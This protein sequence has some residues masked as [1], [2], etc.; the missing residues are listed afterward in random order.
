MLQALDQENFKNYR[1]VSNLP[2]ASKIVEKVVVTRLNEHLTQNNL[3]EINQ[4]AYR[5]HH[6]V[7]TALVRVFD[8]MLNAIDSKKCILLI[9]LDLSS[10]FD[11]IDHGILLARMEKMLGV[12][13]AALNWVKS[14]F[15]GRTQTVLINGVPSKAHTLN[16]GVPQG[17]VF[18]PFSFPPYAFAIA[19]IAR[20]FGIDVHLYA[21]NTQLYLAFDVGEEDSSLQRLE[22]CVAA[23]RQWMMINFLKLN[24]DKS[25][26]LLIGSKHQ[27]QKVEGVSHVVI[28]DSVVPVVSSARN[29]GVIVD[30]NLSMSQHIGNVVRSC[31]ASLHQIS[32]V[33]Q[34]LT[35]DAIR[36]LVH[37]L[38]T[39]KLDNLNSLYIGLPE[40][41]IN[42][43]Q[44]IQNNSARLI[45]HT[46]K[47]DHITP[48]LIELHWLPV[49]YRIK[50]KILLLT[51]KCLHHLAPPYLTNLLQ[52]YQPQRSLRSSNHGLLRV[53]KTRLK[54]FGDRAFSASAPKLWNDL[55]TYVKD[56]D[57]IDL[58]KT[59]LKTHLFKIAY[60]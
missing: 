19:A 11:T 31:Y 50:Y 58:F 60:P 24:D 13:G 22:A 1:P 17:S 43:L 27:L 56:C 53:C 59:G 25:E 29:I 40:Y 6:S 4:S 28:G 10:A 14:Y 55:P 3:H 39:S 38:V 51:F 57:T 34:F 49:E 54:T 46:R 26:F 52:P 18:G 5:K 21:D 7:E 44:M 9:L 12:S 16:C 33:Q 48:V 15:T 37:S 32:Q 2:F 20:Q 45:T 47:H 35:K 30:N 36:T 23:I 41:L 42:R 8:D